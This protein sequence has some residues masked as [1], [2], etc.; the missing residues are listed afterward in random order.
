MSERSLLSDRYV[1]ASIMRDMDILSEL[2]YEAYLS[3]Y[4]DLS[5]MQKIANVR[6]VIYVQCD[7]KTCS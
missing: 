1:F 3:C 2:E 4:K 5:K 7:P 6:G